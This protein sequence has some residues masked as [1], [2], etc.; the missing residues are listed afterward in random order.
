MQAIRP[1]T[2]PA[3]PSPQTSQWWGHQDP[4]DHG[5]RCQCGRPH[6]LP[7][8][9]WGC[10]SAQGALPVCIRLL[11]AI[12]MARKSRNLVTSAC[13]SGCSAWALPFDKCQKSAR[14]QWIFRWAINDQWKQIV[15]NPVAA[16][17]SIAPNLNNFKR[18]TFS[19]F[20]MTW[21]FDA[22]LKTSDLLSKGTMLP[23]CPMDSWMSPSHK[24]ADNFHFPADST[25]NRFYDASPTNT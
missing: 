13:V 12:R 21:C 22:S 19:S 20:A 14:N 24:T 9:S 3:P 7:L 2:P 23:P 5:C 25:V 4:W 15:L 10:T 17:W 18:S 1:R 16:A 6:K 11:L 8:C